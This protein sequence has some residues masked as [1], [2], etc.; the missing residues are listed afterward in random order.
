MVICSDV[1]ETVSLSGYTKLSFDDH[2]NTSNTILTRYKNR[3]TDLHLSLHEFFH[4]TK[5]QS[6]KKGR[7]YVPHYVG[8]SGQPVYPVSENYARVELMKHKP[9]SSTNDLSLLTNVIDEFE[10][11]IG[12]SRCPLTVKLSYERAKLKYTQRLRGQKE[13]LSEDQEFSNPTS[14]VVDKDTLDTLAIANIIGDVTNTIENMENSE[15][16]SGKNYD[17]AKRI[18]EVSVFCT[19]LFKSNYWLIFRTNRKYNF[20][21][22]FLPIDA[23]R[24][25]NMA[26]E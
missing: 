1:I 8:G 20:L 11:F 24:W 13:T 6:S 2:C 9:W 4:N 26:G 3:T 18:H 15:I 21:L 12:D 10:S 16:N 14:N 25:C 23:K 5:N 19:F 22:I 17:W 7:E